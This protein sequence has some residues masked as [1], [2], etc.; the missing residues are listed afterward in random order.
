MTDDRIRW[1]HDVTPYGPFLLQHE[2]SNNYSGYVLASHLHPT[3]RLQA[4]DHQGIRAPCSG[5]ANN[6]PCYQ[7]LAPSRGHEI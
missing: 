5:F 1:Y 6:M 7:R 2:P 4:R 3:L